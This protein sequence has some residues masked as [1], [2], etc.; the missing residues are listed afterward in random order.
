MKKF[1]ITMMCVI[2]VI[3]MMPAMAFAEEGEVTAD[4]QQ[5]VNPVVEDGNQQD[6]EE[7]IE[8]LEINDLAELKAFRDAVNGGNDYKGKIVT[9]A[10]D[11]DLANEEWTPIGQVT[12]DRA[13]DG[14][15][16]VNSVFKGTFDGQN[17]TISNLKITD[18]EANGVGLFGAATNA[19]I[20]N[21]GTTVYLS[22]SVDST[23]LSFKLDA[24]KNVRI[25][26]KRNTKTGFTSITFNDEYGNEYS[27]Y[28]ETD[29]IK[30]DSWSTL[31]IVGC[32]LIA[33]NIGLLIL[34]LIY[35]NKHLGNRG[36]KIEKES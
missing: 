9:L 22:P 13:G 32:V 1:L 27:G 7:P 12:F 10:A 20:K 5:I 33:I 2:M 21:D 17:H 3:A 26:G 35:R 8:D 15:Y 36:Q 34:I 28:I 25:N 18:S 29:Y 14:S 4:D 11:I 6:P 16:V 24:G 31:Q 23:V 30:S 19:T